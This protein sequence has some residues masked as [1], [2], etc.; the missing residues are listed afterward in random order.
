MATVTR[1]APHTQPPAIPGPC[2]LPV[3]GWRGNLIRFFRDP[4][5]YL[6]AAHRAYGDVAGLVEGST[7][8]LFV[9]G[10][11]HN[12]RLLRD[13]AVFHRCGFTVD[14]PEDS[15]LH[16]LG[17]GLV[18]MNGEL[19]KEQRRLLMPAFTRKRVDAHHQTVIDTTNRLLDRWQPGRPYDI[20]R[21]MLLLTG[22]IT[23]RILF[24]LPDDDA[25]SLNHLVVRWL[26]LNEHP[27]ML[28][29]RRAPG[30]P[31]PRLLALS[32]GLEERYLAILRR[33][34]AE[35]MDEDDA[36]AYLLGARD[37]AGRA[38]GDAALVGHMNILF[39]AANE[40]AYNALAWLLFLLSQHPAI[41]GD[42]LDEL[43]GVLH[44]DAP[45]PE[46]L[47]RLPLLDRVV[48][49]GMRLLPPVVY[50]IRINAE[51]VTFGPYDVPR[52]STIWFSHYVT[53]MLPD[54]YPQP[55][56]FRPERWEGLSPS[57]Y[58]YLPFGAG[59]RA[60]IGG[61]LAGMEI[62]VILAMIAQRYRLTLA[63]GATVDRAVK[64]VLGPKHGMPMTVAPQ[65]GRFSAGE[66]RGN[67]REMVELG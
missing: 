33:R 13:T 24:S 34:R 1:A 6:R 29:P 55:R 38:L 64:I 48:K 30:T 4:V 47:A 5:A 56:R 23:G 53:H 17:F 45:S 35:P 46:Q 2:P 25:D 10:P 21:E 59:P 14:G 12:E 43:R 65:D 31:Y 57:P 54:L 18:S 9:F 15:A 28:L 27:L 19:H 62:R 42:L 61:V 49:E 58:A 36:L 37:A 3:L 26:A 41:M 39:V 16:R 51:P 52:G 20:W 22:R 63:P 66:V 60:C 50:G 32:E 40:A 44:G 7:R 67:I 11:E 8:R